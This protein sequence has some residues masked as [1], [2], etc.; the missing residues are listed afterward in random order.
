MLKHGGNLRMAAQ[1]Y[2]IPLEDWLDLSTGINPQGWPIPELPTDIWQRLPEKDD[3]LMEA[4]VAYYGSAYVLPTAGSQ[5]VIQLLPTLRPASRVGV[6]AP[7]YAE[8]AYAWKRRGHALVELEHDSIEA[9]LPDLDVLIVCN[10]NNPSGLRFPPEKLRAWSKSLAQRDGWLIVDEAFVDATPELSIALYAGQPGLV[11]LRS[12]GKFFGL[13]GARVGA[14]LAW[15]TLL[16]QIEEELGPWTVNGPARLV[17]TRALRDIN[18]QHETQQRLCADS[19]RLATL[20]THHNIAPTGSTPMFQWISH[21]NAQ[22][23]HDA[24]ARQGI[25]T[26]YFNQPCSIRFGL[27]GLPQ[28]WHRLEAALRQISQ[29]LKTA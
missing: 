7:S 13:A 23:L 11:I 2:D 5:P 14:V 8:H 19:T 27:P 6:L 1:Q 15:S 22:A 28:E 26:R 29:T 21:P 17:A 9:I 20:L 16:Q 18:W 4:A 12:L 25:W 24:L 10:P 3:G